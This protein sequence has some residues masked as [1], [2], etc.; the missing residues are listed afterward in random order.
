[1]TRH[2]DIDSKS[3]SARRCLQNGFATLKGTFQNKNGTKYVIHDKIYNMTFIACRQY[4]EEC[5]VKYM[6]MK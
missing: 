5:F 4:C 1:M 3:D 2:Y 6:R